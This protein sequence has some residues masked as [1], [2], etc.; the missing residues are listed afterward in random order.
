MERR[1]HAK[2]AES[3]AIAL[4]PGV[5]WIR[6]GWVGLNHVISGDAVLTRDAL[7]LFPF[8][9]GQAAYGAKVEVART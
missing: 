3:N 8:S 5:V 2:A 9:V 7:S 1:V 6:D 4:P